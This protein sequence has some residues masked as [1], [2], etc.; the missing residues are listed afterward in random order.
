MR[1]TL[2]FVLCAVCFLA[3]LVS[4]SEAVD[5]NYFVAPIRTELQRNEISSKASAYV[6]VF[7]N[8][9]V[10]G[11]R[12]D[13]EALDAESFLADLRPLA[14][15]KSSLYLQ[16]R[17]EFGDQSIPA[18]LKDQLKAELVSLCSSVG[19]QNVRPRVIQTSGKWSD[20]CAA[21]KFE[22]LEG[23][24]EDAAD[25]AL[26]T[27]FPIRTRLSKLAIANVDCIVEIKRPID[28]K[29]TAFPTSLYEKAG[30]AIRDLKLVSKDL[31]MFKVSSTRAG[32]DR[33]EDFFSA[34]KPPVPFFAEDKSFAVRLAKYKA[35]PGLLLAKD[36]GFESIR[37]RHSPGGGAPENLI[38]KQ[39]PDFEL[40]LLDGST[41]KFHRYIQGHPTLLTFWGVACGPCC[42]EAPH[43]SVLDTKYVEQGFRVLAINGYDES[44]DVVSEYATKA[45]LTHPIALKGGDV[46]SDVYDVGAYPTSFWIDKTGKVVDYVVGA[47]SL[48][49]LEERVQG[50]LDGKSTVSLSATQTESE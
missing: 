15:P 19:F 6:I 10:K 30:D 36:L 14:T 28:G 3:S 46:S 44:R 26:V 22:E 49:V 39:A 17:Y 31:L 23:A 43:L 50:F 4:R 34:R 12:L 47:L 1:P 20:V 7:C 29:M 32:R 11:D 45:G 9:L 5:P 42:W 40:E 38:G 27:A 8:P 21:A 37:Y 18:K 2:R 33:I 24:T 16:L 25:N 13:L 48:E 35:S 41:V